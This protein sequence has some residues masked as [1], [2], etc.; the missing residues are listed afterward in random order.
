MLI[1]QGLPIEGTP[2]EL[3]A[4]DQAKMKE[5]GESLAGKRINESNANG[6]PEEI[7]KKIEEFAT[8]EK[9]R[10]NIT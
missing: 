4:E 7:A 8:T 10:C 2:I 9:T 6:N 5:F 1:A 3:T